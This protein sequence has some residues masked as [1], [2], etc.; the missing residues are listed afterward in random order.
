M[1]ASDQRGSNVTLS[2]LRASPPVETLVLGG[3]G[4]AALGAAAYLWISVRS[5][6]DKIVAEPCA[7]ARRC[8]AS[9]VTSVRT[10]LIVGDVLAGVGLAAIGAGV[11]IWVAKNRSSNTALVLVPTGGARLVTRF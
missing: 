9:D 4:L 3:G 1:S 7:A 6:L 8:S 2:M 5:D 10:R 11:W